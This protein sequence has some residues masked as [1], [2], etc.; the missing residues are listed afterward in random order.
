MQ[1]KHAEDYIAEKGEKFDSMLEALCT[2][3]RDAVSP[4]KY[5]AR[6]D[7][8]VPRADPHRTLVIP[9][10]E[11]R[12]RAVQALDLGA[13]SYTNNEEFFQRY[14]HFFLCEARPRL[15]LHDHWDFLTQNVGTIRECF[16][17][18]PEANWDSPLLISTLEAVR[19]NFCER[20]AKGKDPMKLK[21]QIGLKKGVS[22]DLNVLLRWIVAFGQTGPSLMATTALLGKE[23]T[24]RRMESAIEELKDARRVNAVGYPTED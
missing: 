12:A 7:S 17:A 6:C 2:S 10:I 22:R 15:L 24:L 13:T 5:V 20:V 8:C 18:I 11:V 9:D 14:S 1:K 4:E 3:I 16:A 19:E 21:D 23:E